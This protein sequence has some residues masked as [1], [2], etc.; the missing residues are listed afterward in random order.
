MT[1]A[2]SPS[3]RRLLLRFA[4]GA[5]WV[6]RARLLEELRAAPPPDAI[7]AGPLGLRHPLIGALVSAPAVL[8]TLGAVGARV[9][10]AGMRALRPFSNA[11]MWLVG[12]HPVHREVAHLRVRVENLI[13]RLTILGLA[14]EAAGRELAGEALAQIYAETMDW[15][16]ESRQLRHLIHESSAGLTRGMMNELR[17]R[18]SDADEMA[19]N[20]VRRIRKRT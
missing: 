12:F 17:K 13:A 16:G 5:L 19:D 8:G 4:I 10:R 2:D 18:S 20:L 1:V 15:L 6:G 7:E 3:D 11:G 9:L 14:E